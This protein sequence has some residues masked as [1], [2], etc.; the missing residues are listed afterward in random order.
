MYKK[1]ST[2]RLLIRPITRE[3]GNFILELVNSNGW[4][5][6]IGDRNVRDVTDAEKYIQKI[7]NNNKYFY[8][9][10]QL[11]DTGE[12]VGIITFLYRDNQ[13]YPDIGFAILPKFEK[14]GYAF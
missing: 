8:N 5:K 1:L 13:K 9:V 11:N 3:D 4:L 12:S 2:R 10:I 6:Y 14:K 7:L